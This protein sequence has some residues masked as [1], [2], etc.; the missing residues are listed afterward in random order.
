MKVLILA[1]G[2]SGNAA[3]VCS[4][5]TSLLVAGEPLMKQIASDAPQRVLQVVFAAAADL[6]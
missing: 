3:L 1:S 6:E 4:G 2:S 5:D